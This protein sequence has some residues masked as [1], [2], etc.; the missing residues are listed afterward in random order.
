MNSRIKILEIKNLQ[1]YLDVIK[2]IEENLAFKKLWFRGISDESYGLEP[3]LYRK[4]ENIEIEKQ[5]LNRFKTRALPFVDDK[6]NKTYWEWLFIMQHYNVP[7]RLLDWS[8]SALLGLAFA[9]LYR[10]EKHQEKDAAVWC[11]DAETLNYDY[12]KGLKPN[13]PIP[14]IT[15]ETVKKIQTYQDAEIPV[16]FP[17]AVYGP[18]NNVRIIAQKGVFTLFP[19]KEKFKLED[20][21][22]SDKFLVKIIVPKEV[23]ELVRKQLIIMGI[24]ENNVFPGLDSIAKEINREILKA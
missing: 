15:D 14:S 1:D 17:I 21:D 24:T 20:L 6:G 18:L 13:E 22:V 4:T 3:S 9:V 7:T 10:K 8:E 23:I 5:L 16:D 19:F 11:L 12:T 2:E